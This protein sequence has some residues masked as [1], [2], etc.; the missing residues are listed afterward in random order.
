LYGCDCGCLIDRGVI[1]AFCADHPD[2]CCRD[3]QVGTPADPDVSGTRPSLA[4][5]A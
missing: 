1:M 4:A 3:L 2:W 5:E